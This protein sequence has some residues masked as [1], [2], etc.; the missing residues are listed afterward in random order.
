MSDKR[1]TISDVA[2]EAGVSKGTVSAVINDK[3]SVS[4][5]TRDRVMAVIQRLNYRPMAGAD[6]SAGAKASIGLLIKEADNPFYSEIITSA[7][8]RATAEGYTLLVTT[9]EGD[10]TGERLIFELL[11]AKDVDGVIINPVFSEN[12][13]LSPIFE[14]KRR[15]VP[16]VLLEEIRGVVASRVDADNT[17]ATHMATNYLIQQGH[18]RI[19]HFSGPTYSFHTDLRSA[20]FR[21]AFSESSLILAEDAVIPTGSRL[22]DGYRVG[23]QTFGP[24]GPEPRPTGVVCYND[25]VAIG[26]LRALRELGLRVPDDVSVIGHDDLDL[27]AY[28]PL[29]LTTVRIPKKEMA[30]RAVRILIQHIETRQPMPPERVIIPSRLIVREST[31]PLNAS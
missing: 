8:A 13:D 30:D 17:E 15:N 6:R 14:L 3:D 7:R 18:T 10:S 12:A 20:G 22:E 16:I 9:S 1:P 29:G 2:R 5:A 28:F 19:V 24:D 27:L 31:R 4:E 21:R 25:L 26:L 11:R 23:L